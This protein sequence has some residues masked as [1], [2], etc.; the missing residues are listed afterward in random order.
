MAIL[1][2]KY[3]RAIRDATKVV[4]NT[5][6]GIMIIPVDP[7]CY[8]TPLRVSSMGPKGINGPPAWLLG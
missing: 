1:G 2:Q 5:F 6:T 3:G 4:L 7:P 8:F